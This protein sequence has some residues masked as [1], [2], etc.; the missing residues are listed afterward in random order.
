MNKIFLLCLL[1]IGI[2]LVGCAEEQTEISDEEIKAELE[3][4]PDE[5]LDA[6]AEEDSALTGQGSRIT[7]HYFV[8]INMFL[9]L[10]LYQLQKYY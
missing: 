4:L 1:V 3:Q 2:L 5:E 6:I 7:K 9:H 8:K 10:G